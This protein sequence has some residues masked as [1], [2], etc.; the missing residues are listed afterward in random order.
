MS[1]T[2]STRRAVRT[3]AVAALVPVALLLSACGSSGSPGTT[4]VAAQSGGNG[5]G[6]NGSGSGGNGSGNG[7]GGFGQGGGS[8]PGASGL[9]AAASPGQLQVQGTDAQT[10]VTYGA[11]TRFT[12]VETAT[13]AVGDCVT[14]TGTPVS[15]SSSALT[16]TTVRIDAKVN[17]ACPAATGRPGAG[18]GNGGG[19]GGGGNGGGFFGGQSG[20]PRP[21]PSGVPSGTARDF[22]FLSGTVTAVS[23]GTVTVQGVLRTARFGASASP[24]PTTPSSLTF[25]VD[26]T[27][28]ISQTVAATSKAAVVGMCATAIGKADDRGDIAATVITVSKPAADGCRAAAGGFGGFGF[29]RGNGSGSGGSGGGSGSGSGTSA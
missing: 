12:Q 11:S 10:T 23:G 28:A 9:I 8:F 1:Q 24:Q 4:P 16:A 21:R 26:S 20:S 6:G 3:A 17:G 15:G 25:T 27:T 13:V 29:G 5:S 7:G 18:G 2:P 19:N 22:A 14:A